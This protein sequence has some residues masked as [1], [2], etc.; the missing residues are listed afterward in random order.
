MHWLDPVQAAIDAAN[1]PVDVFFRDDDAGWESDRLFALIHRFEAHALPLDVAVIPLALDRD[2]AAE[3]RARAA[4]TKLALHQ[5]GFAHL[6]HEPEGRKFEFGPSRSHRQQGRD[7]EIGA[8]RLAGLLGDAVQPIFTPPWNRCTIETAH[9]LVERG[10]RVLSRESRAAPFDLPGLQELP[11]RLDWL[12][13]H[14]G[15]RLS[16]DEFGERLAQAIYDG[17]PVGVMFHHAAMDAAELDRADELLAL[18][19][20][21]PRVRAGAILDW[22]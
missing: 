20:G 7:I 16:P 11:I 9:A 13:H 8:A 4:T 14:H 22:V 10:F 2:L 17:G 19:A 21:H 1:R 5:H 18:V 12:A 6:N 3:L 15:I